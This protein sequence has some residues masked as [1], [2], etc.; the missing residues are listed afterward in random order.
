MSQAAEHPLV[1]AARAAQVLTEQLGVSPEVAIVLGSGWSPALDELGQPELELAWSDLPGFA[2]TTALGHSGAVLLTRFGGRA[3]LVLSGR[4]HLYEQR[5]AA[6]VVHSVR[7]AVLAG[8]GT[9]ILTNAAGAIRPDFTIGQPVLIS[10]HINLTG[11]SPLLGPPPPQPHHDRFLDLSHL[12]DPGLR[13]LA[14]AA[15][16]SL[17]EG[18]YAGV[19]GPQYET[20]AEIR[21]L[22]A[23]GAD[24][25][26]M[27]TV[28]EAIAAHHL[29]ARV[30]GVSLVTNLAAGLAPAEL[31]GNQVLR[32]G[33]NSAAALG[34]LLG[35]VVEGLD[36]H[37]PSPDG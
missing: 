34:R 2:P 36:Q 23:A 32:V 29:G 6:A 8:A 26:G 37:R 33:R 5:G 21:M 28:L 30:L 22:R 3:V 27:S 13:A 16:P 4:V 12:Y 31:D 18:V 17:R 14:Q 24:L 10:D 9:V 15:Q 25:V 1:A 35:Q 20:P 11:A 19:L 7:T